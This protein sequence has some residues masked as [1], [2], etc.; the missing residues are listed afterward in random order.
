MVLVARPMNP[1]LVVVLLRYCVEPVELSPEF[2]NVYQ[3][4]L[5]SP[6]PLDPG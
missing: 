4:N 1:Q 5:N 6:D 3:N 2:P